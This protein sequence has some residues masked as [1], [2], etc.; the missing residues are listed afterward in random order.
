MPGLRRLI[1]AACFAM[2]VIASVSATRADPNV[3]VSGDTL[4]ANL[5]PHQL[6][7][8]TMQTYLLNTYDTLYRYEGNPPVLQPWL[9]AS[10]SVSPDGLTWR[11]KL[12]D[13]AKFHD[14]S[15]ITAE[16]VVYSFRRVLTLGKAPAGALAPILKPANVTVVAPD[17]VQLRIDKPYAP[18]LAT[19][20][21][22]AIVNAHLLEANTLNGDWGSA[23]LANHE[24]GSGAYQLDTGT[25]A[26]QER[27]DMHRFDG[28]FLG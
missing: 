15:P 19:L 6:Y 18:L 27:L 10:G 24:A 8:V 3:L 23:W 20:P 13:G 17:E 22:V 9:A 4:P 11:F 12:R 7:D 14:G 26:P 28:H 21:I 5:D 25:Y 16:D 1:M 2:G